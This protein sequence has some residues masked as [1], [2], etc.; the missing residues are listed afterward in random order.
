M[1]RSPASWAVR[2]EELQEAPGLLA[3]GDL[4][5]LLRYLRVHGGALP[6]GEVARLVAGAA[7]LAGFDDLALAAA[8]VA[9]GEGGSGPQDARVLF[10]FGSACLERG[11]GY[12]AVRPLAF[13]LE[14]APDAAPV[15]SELVTAL[16]HDGQHARAVA[17]LEE[18]ASAMGWLHRFQYVYNAL[19]A[20]SLDKAADG[21][22]RLPRTS[23]HRVDPG[24]RESPPHAR[25]R[26]H[27]PRRDLAGSPGPA[28]LALC[29]DRRCAG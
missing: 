6:L 14:L 29:P 22:R 1:Y 23:G 8:A 9:D 16:E 2:A 12:L 24:T 4:P 20:G 17:V 21:F 3:A 28:R 10:D 5:G 18:H 19:M 26:R 7:R 11:A 15:L 25:P 27:R 13:A